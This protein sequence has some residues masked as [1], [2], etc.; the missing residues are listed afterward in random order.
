MLIWIFFQ[1][2]VGGDGFAN[3][4]EH[5]ANAVTIDSNKQW[6]IDKYVNN[7][8]KFWAPNLNNNT[9]R[10]NA[11]ADLNDH[12]LEIAQ[13][14][15]QYLIITSHDV[16][17]KYT[18]AN[19]TLSKEKHVKLLLVSN[20]YT[21][22][23]IT[24][25]HKNLREVDMDQIPKAQPCTIHPDMDLTANIANLQDSWTSTLALTTSIG[26]DLSQCFYTHYQDILTGKF[27]Y[28]TPGIRY[29]QSTVDTNNITRYTQ[30]N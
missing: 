26:L 3:L 24:G 16:A 13:S 17:L 1:P 21:E 23:L 29:Y 10:Y 4:L 14:N 11:V 12:Q 22:L 25:L 7:R 19:D 28:T 27:L 2:G 30:Q 5:S 8:A 6:R 18:F 15:D 9:S 20:N